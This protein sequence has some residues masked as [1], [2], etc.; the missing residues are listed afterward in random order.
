MARPTRRSN[1]NIFR[2]L[3]FRGAEAVHLRLR[4][5]LMIALVQEI[6]SR[7]WSQGEAA[8]VLGVSQ[9]RVS[10]LVRGRIDRFSLDALV[11][12]LARTGRRVD[13]SIG[14]GRAA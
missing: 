3:G 8:R 9:P 1:G 12:L 13:L 2:E 6:A 14:R 10:D 7:E 11:E 5:E 4:S